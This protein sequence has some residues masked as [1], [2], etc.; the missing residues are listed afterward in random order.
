[1]NGGWHRYE[2]KSWAREFG[3]SQRQQLKD[4]LKTTLDTSPVKVSIAKPAGS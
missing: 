2:I 3:K 1:M 4:S